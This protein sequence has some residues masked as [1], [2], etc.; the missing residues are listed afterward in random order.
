VLEDLPSCDAFECIGNQR[1]SDPGGSGKKEMDMIFLHGKRSNLPV[2]L[3]A[4][5]AKFCL[6]KLC[7]LPRK[8]LLAIRRTPYEMIRY[9][10]GDM[11]G[12]LFVHVSYCSMVYHKCQ[13][14]KE[15]WLPIGV[16]L[17]SIFSF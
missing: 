8:Y 5:P 17:R 7:Q 4:Q 3:F 13:G 12:M 15:G 1:G 11:F 14:Y 6:D 2:V 9:F 16:N 10:V